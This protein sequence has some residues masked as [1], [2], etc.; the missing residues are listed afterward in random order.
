MRG[1]RPLGS[2]IG[3]YVASLTAAPLV[4]GVNGLL[5]AVVGGDFLMNRQWLGD[6]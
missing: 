5:M 4:L 6:I 3:G 2:L 1:R